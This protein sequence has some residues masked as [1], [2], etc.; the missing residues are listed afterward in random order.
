MGASSGNR[1]DYRRY[2]LFHRGAQDGAYSTVHSSPTHRSIFFFVIYTTSKAP[3]RHR[4]E[5]LAEK[6]RRLHAP[7]RPNPVALGTY[8]D[9]GTVVRYQHRPPQGIGAEPS[10]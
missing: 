5:T 10:R 1:Y 6:Y 3:W 9:R 8:P 4:L 2:R 7:L